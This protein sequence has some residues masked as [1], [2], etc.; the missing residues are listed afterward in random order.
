MTLPDAFFLGLLIYQS[1]CVSL[2]MSLSIFLSVSPFV[3]LLVSLLSLF[4]PVLQKCPALR[5]VVIL[6]GAE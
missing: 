1:L 3:S 5:W 2:C 6:P 4:H